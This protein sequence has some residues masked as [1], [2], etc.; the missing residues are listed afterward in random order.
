MAVKVLMTANSSEAG[1]GLQ[2][3]P[4]FQLIAADLRANPRNPKGRLL[5]I[6]Y[7]VAHGVLFLPSYLKPLGYVYIALYKFLTEYILGSEIHWRAT[8]GPG[9]HISHGYGLVIHSN[10]I[11]GEGVILRHGVTIGVAHTGDHDD[12]PTI[13]DG[14]EFG[15]NAVVIGRIQIGDGAKIGAG[16]VVT[17]SVPANGLAVG[18]PARIIGK[19]GAAG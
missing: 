7:R 12:V 8:I 17:R 18:N 14:V 10:T 3:W 2:R 13:G 9:M 5:C 1:I 16:A 19:G 15:A 11:V 6:L 4:L